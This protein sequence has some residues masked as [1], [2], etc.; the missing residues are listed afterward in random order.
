MSRFVRVNSVDA[1]KGFRVTLCKLTEELKGAL[2]DAGAQARR[3]QVWL[4]REQA[5][6]WQMQIR[7]RQEALNQ[8][9]IALLQKQS[10][11]EADGGRASCI[12]E[13]QTLAL[14][15]RRLDEANRKLANVQR[16][17]PKLD[18]EVQA[19]RGAVQ[20][21]GTA[22]DV[23]VPRALARLDKMA[24]ALDDYVAVAPP[25]AEP[26]VDE[27]SATPAALG[28]GELVSM[29]RPAPARPDRRLADYQVLRA[30]TCSEPVR[31]HTPTGGVSVA[32][33]DGERIA[34]DDRK[35]LAGL[36][37]AEDQSGPDAKVVLIGVDA[38]TW[39]ILSP[40]VDEG[41]VPNVAKLIAEG[42]SGPV[43]T[44]YPARSPEIWNSI[45]TGKL[46]R[47]HGIRGFMTKDRATGR[48][49]P[50][51]S[52]MRKCSAIWEIVGHYGKEVGV[53]G[54]WNTWPAE[55]VNG[56]MVC[57]IIGYKNRD[58]G[59]SSGPDN[60][61]E[62]TR[63]ARLKDSSFERQTHPEELYDEIKDLIRPE[64]QIEDAH[65]FVK[66]L[67]AR[68]E[69]L[70]E[71]EKASLS[72]LTNVYN[73]DRTY[74]EAAKYLYTKESPDLLAFYLS[75]VDVVGHKYWAYMQPDC[76]S[77][78]VPEQRIGLY[79]DL[80]RDYYLFID[81]VVG[82]FMSERT[83]ETVITVISDHGMSADPRKFAR[84]QINSGRHVDEDGVFIAS[85][86][87][88]REHFRAEDVS[89]LDI[90]PTLLASY[91]LPAGAD[92]DG[93]V[94][95]EIFEDEFLK[96]RPP[97]C[98]KTHDGGRQHSPVPVESP[99]DREIEERLRSL[100]YIE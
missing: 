83:P 6:H 43:R 15:Q 88:I 58:L 90:T 9:R 35:M 69:E 73:S 62:P 96:A 36:A 37:D 92:M 22:V 85:G 29:A 13:R 49:R 95:Y 68:E 4:E 19:Y 81:E 100:G 40:L 70:S 53:V 24:E 66:R 87:Y 1:L 28:V 65:P 41:R 16:W 54:W 80:I 59:I 47:K 93:R 30:R 76:F 55:Q 3:A 75:G 44:L 89:V 42:C 67:W 77:G 26:D 72:L 63:K 91:G 21:M 2:E 33:P 18:R 20:G 86:K 78:K 8:A 5:G 51:T 34:E 56:S 98:V 99:V 11:Q 45:S 57:G 82:W 60:I 94:A 10:R 64:D 27:G 38:L 48:L 79:G 52:N 25:M 97:Y 84:N 74:V 71:I 23:D 14:A 39:D 12:E 32:W 46:P 31:E 17:I 50:L 61:V 7:K